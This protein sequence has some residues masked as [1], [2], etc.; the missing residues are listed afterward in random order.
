[1][2]KRAGGSLPTLAQRM[3]PP[4]QLSVLWRQEAGAG[5]ALFFLFLLIYSEGDWKNGTHDFPCSHAGFRSI[6]T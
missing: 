1:M 2:E 4:R 6:L 3:G 5:E